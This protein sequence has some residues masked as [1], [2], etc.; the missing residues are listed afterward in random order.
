MCNVVKKPFTL[1]ILSL[2]ISYLP[3]NSLKA[4]L[5]K[6]SKLMTVVLASAT[7]AFSPLLT[8]NAFAQAGAGAAAAGSAGGAAAGATAAT[9]A[10]VGGLSTAAIVGGVVVVGAGIAVA[11]SSKGSSSGGGTTGTT[12]P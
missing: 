1:V 5:V 8:H 10:A 9:T 11:A 12:S 4:S 6:T 3:T 7:I 2:L